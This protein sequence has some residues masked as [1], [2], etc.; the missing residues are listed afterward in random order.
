MCFSITS[1]LPA[2]LSSDVLLLINLM[3]FINDYL[4]E[5]AARD[6]STASELR[7]SMKPAVITNESAAAEGFESVEAYRDALHEFLNSN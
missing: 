2:A 4:N 6:G 1:R 3:S 5:L 7:R